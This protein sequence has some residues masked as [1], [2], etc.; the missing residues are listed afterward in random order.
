MAY[1]IVDGRGRAVKPTTAELD[2]IKAQPGFSGAG[3][4]M[5][6][7]TAHGGVRLYRQVIGRWMD[8]SLADCEA[9]RGLVD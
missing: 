7:E 5:V 6:S 8:A 1:D 4:Y 3:H 2:A 9:L